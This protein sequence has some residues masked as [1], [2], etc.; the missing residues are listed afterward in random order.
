MFY[1][2]NLSITL[3]INLSI[4]VFSIVFSIIVCMYACIDGMA[5]PYNSNKYIHPFGIDY[6]CQPLQSNSISN[7]LPILNNLQLAQHCH[8]NYHNNHILHICHYV[9]TINKCTNSNN[10]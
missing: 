7:I 8:N 6:M 1:I 3:S 2:I 9:I 5:T 4:I 10:N